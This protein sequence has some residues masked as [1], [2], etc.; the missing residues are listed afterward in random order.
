MDIKI[1]KEMFQNRLEDKPDLVTECFMFGVYQ[2]KENTKGCF[3]END[4]WFIYE[5]DEKKIVSISG[6][7]YRNDIIVAIAMVMHCT[8]YFDEY[9]FSEDGLKK[10]IHN[11]F[12]TY[13]DDIE[14]I[15][16]TSNDKITDN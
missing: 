3:Q 16:E 10:Y 4:S 5:I 11:H 1:I 7:F 8:K 2:E 12:R 13:K 9:K 6:P 14:S 15:K